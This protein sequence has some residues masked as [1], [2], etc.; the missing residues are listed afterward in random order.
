VQNNYTFNKKTIQYPTT[1]KKVD[2]IPSKNSGLTASA[3][4]V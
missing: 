4:S 1:I 3:A 2:C